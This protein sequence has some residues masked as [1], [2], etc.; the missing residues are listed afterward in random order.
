M[1]ELLPT[2]PAALSSVTDGTV[3]WAPN[4]A[5]AQAYYN[6]PK[7]VGKVRQ[8]G[9]NILPV[10]G[11]IHSYDT[12][13]QAWSQN[14]KHSKVS[15]EFLDRA[16]EAEKAQ[17][18]A[19]VDALLAVEREQI[20]Q[21]VATQMAEKKAQMVAWL[22]ENDTQMAAKDA[23]YKACFHQLKEILRLSSMPEVTQYKAVPNRASPPFL[24]VRLSVYSGSG[25]NDI[26]LLSMMTFVYIHMLLNA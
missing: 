4:Y 6:K 18:K 5:Y 25:N 14:S 12:P 16:L 13:S 19:Q 10:Q 15:Q 9:P 8:V 21:H 3:R 23:M 22:A 2:D 7:Y 20:T 24:M 26:F 1:E 17:P 11:S